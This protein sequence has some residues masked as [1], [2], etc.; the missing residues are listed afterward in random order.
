MQI[1]LFR[2]YGDE[3]D[4]GKGNRNKKFDKNVWKARRC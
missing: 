1:T 3:Y 2:K 4:P